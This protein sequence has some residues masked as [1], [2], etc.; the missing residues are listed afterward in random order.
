MHLD[1]FKEDLK[2]GWNIEYDWHLYSIYMCNKATKDVQQI[3]DGT[4]SRLVLL[5]RGELDD[6]L[7]RREYEV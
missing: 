7:Y 5:N 1:Q 4:I 2:S 6:D 3:G